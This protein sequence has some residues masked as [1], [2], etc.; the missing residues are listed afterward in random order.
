MSH[1]D[2]VYKISYCDCEAS[3]VGQT[4][5]QLRTRV[6]EHRKDINKKSGSPSVI[7]THRLSS[8]HDFDWDDV[9]ILNK[10]GSY[11]KRLVSEMVNIKR[12]LK[13]LNLQN[14]TE[15]LSDDY[16]PILNMFSPL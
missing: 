2:V 5:R 8:G 12:Q 16:L 13:S 3:Y 10:E 15:F 4:K 1:C 14:D 9:Q 6:N 11:K 7:S